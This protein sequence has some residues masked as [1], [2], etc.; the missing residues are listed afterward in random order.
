MKFID[1]FATVCQYGSE[2]SQP[3]VAVL[4]GELSRHGLPTVTPP[5]VGKIMIS[6]IEPAGTNNAGHVARLKDSACAIEEF[7]Q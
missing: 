1:L 5:N 3:S 6:L 4:E 2:L 7:I